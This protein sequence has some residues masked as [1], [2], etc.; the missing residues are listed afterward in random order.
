M[1][2]YRLI[3]I[4]IMMAGA[5]SQLYGAGSRFDEIHVSGAVDVTLVNNP[6]SAGIVKYENQ[7]AVDVRKAA[8]ALYILGQSVTSPTARVAVTVYAEGSVKVI[9]VSGRAR[10]SAGEI[11][12]PDQ[13]AVIA[14]GAASIALSGIEAAN[15]NVSL[16][17]SGTISIHGEL[18]ASTL[19][20][21]LIGSG[22]LKADAITASRMTVN[23]RGSGKMIFA[24]SAR[25]CDA[26][27]RGTGTID[28]RGLVAGSMDLKLYGDGHIF[29][30]SG[31]RVTTSGD[32]DRI[33]QV[34]PYQ[35]L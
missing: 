32:T 14:S 27:G 18:T 9:E 25:D 22:T 35:P 34:K 13:L 7:A 1:N 29:Y 19:N 12:S 20:L 8:N 3:F 21:S 5:V 33:I 10:L 28:L 26:V 31:V 11:K 24:G 2:V 16:S 6:D 17:G 4:L 23:Q 30:P 15:V